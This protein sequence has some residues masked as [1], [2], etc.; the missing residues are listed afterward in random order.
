M[1]AHVCSYTHV[2][3]CLRVYAYI[4]VCMCFAHVCVSLHACACFAC[5]CAGVRTFA[6]VR[7][8]SSCVSVRFFAGAQQCPVL[9]D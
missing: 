7:G 1:R 6:S 5:T 8:N 2:C 4:C 9:D 3:V